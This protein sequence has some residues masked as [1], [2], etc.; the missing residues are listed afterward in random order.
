MISKK[1]LIVSATVLLVIICIGIF[2]TIKFANPWVRSKIAEQLKK[3]EQGNGQV[4]YDDLDVDML[5]GDLDLKNFAIDR[6]QAGQQYRLS[7]GGL[8]V[9]GLGV[10]AYIF[11]GQIRFK[12]VRIEKP[13]ITFNI[14]Q[15]TDTLHNKAQDS[16]QLPDIIFKTLKLSDG[17]FTIKQNGSLVLTGKFNIKG[18]DFN[19][20]PKKKLR[21][22]YFDTDALHL[23]FSDLRFLFPDSLYQLNIKSIALNPQKGRA[24]IDSVHLKSRYDKYKLAHVAGHEKDWVDINLPTVVIQGLDLAQIIN[25]NLYHAESI[26]INGFDALIFRDKRLPFPDKPDTKLPHEV[27][28][29][30]NFKMALDT[31]RLQ[32]GNI[33][34]QEFVARHSEPGQVSFEKLY[35]TGYNITNVDSL[36][37]KVNYTAHLDARSMVMG[38]AL[39]KAAF[40][41]PLTAGAQPYTVSGNMKN[42][43]LTVFN[44]MITQVDFFKIEK[45]HMKNLTFN[46]HYNT[47]NA[48]GKMEFR[49][50]G[51]KISTLDKET[52]ESDGLGEEI[53]SL[54]ANA[55]VVKNSNQ[56]KSGN[57]LRIGEIH[58]A[59]NKKKSIFNYWWKSLLTGFRSSTGVSSAKEKVNTGAKSKKL[60]SN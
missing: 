27:M 33:R 34:Y 13:A 31:V 45:G 22:K 47:E 20:D 49:Y 57:P 17:T 59:R 55:V 1:S 28:S 2:L 54:I 53:K 40:T 44:P 3:L 5:S 43:N 18:S 24:R 56:S 37:K 60:E 32:R 9:H 42:A 8:H 4:T 52:K 25:E 41:F 10:L 6:Q 51:L 26:A 30:L 39:L 23:T 21:Y 7:F 19:M 15:Q 12:N 35:A 58:F 38:K 46:F 29:E 16:L 50:E 48:D 36:M 14:L 11:N